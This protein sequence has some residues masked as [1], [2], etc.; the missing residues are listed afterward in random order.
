M[1]R[2]GNIPRIQ[3]KKTP[4]ARPAVVANLVEAMSICALLKLG[5]FTPKVVAHF[6]TYQ[7]DPIPA[8]SDSAF[9]RAAAA[10]VCGRGIE[11]S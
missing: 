4:K 3:P 10:M 1:K 7:A 9:P 2:R 11:P 6:S 8:T 5:Y